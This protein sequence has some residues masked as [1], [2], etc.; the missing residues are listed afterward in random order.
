[1]SPERITV[2]ELAIQL[3]QDYREISRE[4][5]SYALSQIKAR[6]GSALLRAEASHLES[7]PPGT[8]D[9]TQHAKTLR[10]EA[11]SADHPPLI[12]TD[13]TLD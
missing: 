1:M 11:D 10:T 12:V 6:H 5:A 8:H 4:S 2:D 9:R 3:M 13:D 7:V